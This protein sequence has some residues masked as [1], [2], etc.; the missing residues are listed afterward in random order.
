MSQ[1]I[2]Q[3]KTGTRL[4]KKREWEATRMYELIATLAGLSEEQAIFDTLKRQ[5]EETFNFS[6]VEVLPGEP[7][8]DDNAKINDS[9]QKTLLIPMETRTRKVGMI[10]VVWEEMELSFEEQRLLHGFGYQGA[11]AIER[12]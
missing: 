5:V 11:L 8:F 3:A 12:V 1:L 10:R 2:G 6:M 4:A 7:P 9:H